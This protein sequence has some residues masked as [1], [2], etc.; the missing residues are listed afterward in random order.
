[1]VATLR[2]LAED[3]ATCRDLGDRARQAFVD[4]YEKEHRCAQWSALFAELF[5]SR[6]AGTPQSAKLVNAESA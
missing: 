2:K 6:R 1:V 5:G 4:E 3:P